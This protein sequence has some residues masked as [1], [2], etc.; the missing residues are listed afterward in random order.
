MNPPPSDSYSSYSSSSSSSSEIADSKTQPYSKNEPP[1]L[2][3][4]HQQQPQS[5]SQSQ[6]QQHERQEEGEG[7]GEKGSPFKDPTNDQNTLQ[8]SQRRRRKMWWG[9]HSTHDDQNLHFAN[10]ANAN[11]DSDASCSAPNSPIVQNINNVHGVPSRTGINTPSKL[12]KDQLLLDKEREMQR[13]KL[14]VRRQSLRMSKTTKVPHDYDDASFHNNNYSEHAEEEQE[15][16]GGHVGTETIRVD[17][18]KMPASPPSVD[19]PVETSQLITNAHVNINDNYET[20]ESAIALTVRQRRVIK[21]VQD[22]DWSNQSQP[23]SPP[24]QN[25]LTYSLLQTRPSMLPQNH[26]NSLTEITQSPSLSSV[27]QSYDD[28]DGAHP[29]AHPSKPLDPK[30]PPASI[31]QIR[32]QKRFSH[33]NS[34]HSMREVMNHPGESNEL[35]DPPPRSPATQHQNANSHNHNHNHNH[36]HKHN[37]N[38]HQHHES[39]ESMGVKLPSLSPSPYVV[40]SP[41]QEPTKYQHLAQA[42]AAAEPDS[43]QYVES[44]KTEHPKS[45]M[46]EET[47][48]MLQSRIKTLERQLNV[49]QNALDKLKKA[50]KPA[51]PQPV[52]LYLHI[53]FIHSTHF[54]DF[55]FCENMLLRFNHDHKKS[56]LLFTTTSHAIRTPHHSSTLSQQKLQ[57]DNSR[58]TS[59]RRLYRPNCKIFGIRCTNKSLMSAYLLLSKFLF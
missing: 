27:S 48:R 44:P 37:Y 40:Q 11:D 29:H 58:R 21:P 22:I 9:S 49:S 19:I 38:N 23:Q 33:R 57:D 39:Q 34:S 53:F 6:S 3:P 7:E 41:I 35:T 59:P 45:A 42:A 47:L 26:M 46:N 28:K 5:Q 36:N 4:T 50:P 31:P 32:S 16:N 56:F 1:E 15:V 2:Q 8:R 52:S 14:L 30:P 13:V 54:F 17:G 20:P 24:S 12:T 51:D 25:D 43:H 18:D 55:I 10:D